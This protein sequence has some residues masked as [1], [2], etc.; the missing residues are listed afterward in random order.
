MKKRKYKNQN[1]IQGQQIYKR[2]RNEIQRK[3][4]KVKEEWLDKQCKIAEEFLKRGRSD[5]AYLE[6]KKLF[7]EKNIMQTL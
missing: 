3:I 6:I 2:I 7:R 5:L 1:N 4:K